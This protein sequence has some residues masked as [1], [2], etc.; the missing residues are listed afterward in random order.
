MQINDILTEDY[1]TEVDPINMDGV[2]VGLESGRS[3]VPWNEERVVG[4]VGLTRAER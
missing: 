2:V 4:T 1:L 3:L